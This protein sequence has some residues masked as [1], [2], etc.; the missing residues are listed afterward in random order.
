MGLGRWVLPMLGVIWIFA[1]RIP[2]TCSTSSAPPSTRE[3]FSASDF[4]LDLLEGGQVTLSGLGG[5]P[6][7]F[8]VDPKGI[9][10]SVVVDDSHRHLNSRIQLQIER[11]VYKMDHQTT[12]G[13]Q[14]H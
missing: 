2:A 10:R 13:Y 5:L 12:H 11:K 14:K 8:S 4:T 7:S 6:K 9:I 1:S 3:G